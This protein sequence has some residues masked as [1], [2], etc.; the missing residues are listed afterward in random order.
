MR[1]SRGLP[2]VFALA[3]TPAA[4]EVD[5]NYFHDD[6][7][8]VEITLPRDWSI[9]QHASYPGLR[10]HAVHVS[11]KAKMT[12]AIER[13]PD[14]TSAR[15]YADENRRKLAEVGFRPGRLEQHPSG[16]LVF[17]STTPHRR[18]AL[19]QAYLTEGGLA[20]IL[21]LSAPP[22]LMRASVR[23]FDDALRNLV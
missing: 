21:T 6:A 8:P 9:S 1:F 3:T 13:V 23:D 4:A 7:Y 18:T 14:G 15:S 12:L 17:E 20:C 2:F 16:A 10:A 19:K 22:N 5:N 11:G